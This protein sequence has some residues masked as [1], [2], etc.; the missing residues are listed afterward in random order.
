MISGVVLHFLHL[1]I[2]FPCISH[3]LPSPRNKL[4]N[5]KLFFGVEKPD[6]WYFAFLTV[7]KDTQKYHFSSHRKNIT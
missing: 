1:P 4:T 3:F 5:S 2:S 7:Y 6:V